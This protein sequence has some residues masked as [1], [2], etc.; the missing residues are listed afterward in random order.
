[1]ERNSGG[2]ATMSHFAAI[3]LFFTP[4]CPH[5][6]PKCVTQIEY[7]EVRLSARI[8]PYVIALPVNSD[9]FRKQVTRS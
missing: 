8:L 9:W 3:L 1:M 2:I 6:E 5:E 4:G 7:V